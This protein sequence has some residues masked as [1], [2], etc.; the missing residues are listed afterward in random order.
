MGLVSSGRGDGLVWTGGRKDLG[1]ICRRHPSFFDPSLLHRLCS[2]LW[3]NSDKYTGEWRRGTMHGR[4]TF[5]WSTK[6]DLYEGEWRDGKMHGRGKKMM[7]NGDVYEGEWV[8][9][10]AHGWGAS[11]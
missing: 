7:A 8:D 4:G 10:K 1:F 9:D 6:G 5:H 3:A 11:G 2:Y